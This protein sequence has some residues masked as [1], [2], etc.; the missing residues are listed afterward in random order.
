MANLAVVAGSRDDL[1]T[2]EEAQRQVLTDLL[3]DVDRHDLWGKVAIPK[4]HAPEDVPELYRLAA[5]RHGVF[6]D[7]ALSEPFGLTLLEAAA[8]GLPIVA[9]ED[10]GPRD[11]LETCRNGLLVNPLEPRSIAEALKHV[12]SNNAQWHTWSRNGLN[13]VR[14]HYTWEGHVQKYVKAV[15]QVLRRERKQI[16]RRVTYAAQEAAPLRDFRYAVVT[17]I[18]NTLLGDR[19]GLER[20]LSW[21]REHANDVLFGVATGRVLAQALEVLARW[22]VDIPDVL[23]T[24]V[25]AEIHYGPSLSPDAGWSRHIR[26]RWRRDALEEAMARVPGLTLQ[27]AA[28]QGPFKLSYDVE[29]SLVPPIEEIQQG[30]QARNLAARLIYSQAAHLDLLPVRASKGLAIRHLAYRKGVALRQFLVAGDSGNDREMLVGDTLAVVVGNHSPELDPLRGIDQIDF[31]GK[32]Y[33]DGILEGVAHY[34]FASVEAT[35]VAAGLDAG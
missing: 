23:I 1:R 27:P 18:D 22:G 5:R 6:V 10:G 11:I 12:L 33:A 14:R 19:D 29:P 32:A 2:A 13:G 30:L 3:L 31:A 34:G 16:R 7:A 9:T 35:A 20:L 15:R 17:D 25:G 8:S 4:R 21:L 28:K 24:S 26:H